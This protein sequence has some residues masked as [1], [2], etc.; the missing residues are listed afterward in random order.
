MS[1]EGFIFEEIDH[2]DILLGMKQISQS[3]EEFKKQYDLF[4]YFVNKQQN[5]IKQI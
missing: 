2:S 5:L 1:R 4:I 3:I